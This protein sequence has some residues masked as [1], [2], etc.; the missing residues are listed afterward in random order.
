MKSPSKFKFYGIIPVTIILFLT[1]G[2][3]AT[4][5]GERSPETK[6][7]T[8]ELKPGEREKSPE[9]LIDEQQQEIQLLR[10]RLDIRRNQLQSARIL[11]EISRQEELSA[12][13]QKNFEFEKRLM[14]SEEL[15]IE[16]LVRETR[17]MHIDRIGGSALWPG[18]GQYLTGETN[19]GI[20][21]GASFAGLLALDIWSYRDTQSRRATLNANAY[22]TFLSGSY[23][24]RYNYAYQR[25]GALFLFT[26][27]LYIASLADAYNWDPDL[28]PVAGFMN[29]SAPDSMFSLDI[30]QGIDIAGKRE[31][32]L[33]FAFTRRF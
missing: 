25:T 8:S 19:R 20:F 12:S 1:F 32:R 11:R 13:L 30:D 33:R 16:R 22:L 14:V 17:E 2:T 6:R 26:G 7:T 10:R 31:D 29:F 9:D 5:H 24:A 28:P 23:R 3:R 21:L 15:R 4:V 27:L 18:Y